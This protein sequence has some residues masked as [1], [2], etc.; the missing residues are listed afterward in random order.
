V[1]ESRLPFIEWIK[2]II[3]SPVRFTMSD[4]DEWIDYG[5]RMEILT[6]N[7]KLMTLLPWDLDNHDKDGE[8]IPYIIRYPTTSE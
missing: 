2:S 8:F 1:E 6:H 7:G 3:K 4:L 5:C